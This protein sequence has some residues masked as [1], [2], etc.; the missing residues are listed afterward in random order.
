MKPLPY[1]LVIFIFM[2]NM[3][4]MFYAIEDPKAHRVLFVV[5]IALCCTLPHIPTRRPS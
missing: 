5:T 3:G 2:C 4:A 1:W